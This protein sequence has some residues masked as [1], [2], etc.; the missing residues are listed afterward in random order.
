MIGNNMKWQAFM[1]CAY[2]CS[3]PFIP[4][5]TTLRLPLFCLLLAFVTETNVLGQ[6]APPA[7]NAALTV[8]QTDVALL[9]RIRGLA[10]ETLNHLRD[11]DLPQAMKTLGQA[12][13][14]AV[15]L[16][17]TQVDIGLAPAAAGLHRQ[18]VQLDAQ[19]RFDLLYEWS[20]PVEARPTIRVLTSL[21][22]HDAPPKAF[23]RAIA[24]RPRDNS[25]SVSEVN[26]IDGLFSSAWLLVMSAEET[27][28]LRRLIVELTALTENGLLNAKYVLTLTR[29]VNAKKRD[30]QLEESLREYIDVLQRQR[31][32]TLAGRGPVPHHLMWQ[33]GYTKVNY[34]P[35][36]IDFKPL[37]FWSGSKWQGSA[38]YPDPNLGWVMLEKL[39]GHTGNHL[40][41]V[42]RWIAPADGTLS[43]AGEFKHLYDQG[44][45]IRARII[46]SRFG[47][48]GEWKSLNESVSTTVESFEVQAWDTIDFVADRIDNN[49]FDHFQWPVQLTLMK[50][51]GGVL[52]YD[53][54]AVSPEPLIANVLSKV[55]LAT[56][57][58][59]HKWLQSSG[60]SIIEKLL[61]D[62][63]QGASPL[64]RP[65]LQR[66]RTVA[67][68]RR[69]STTDLSQITNSQPRHWLAADG[70][71]STLHAQGSSRPHW[72][73]YDKHILQLCGADNGALFFRYP[74]VGEFEFSCEVQQG[75]T[76]STDGGLVYGGLQ[77]M[78]DSG[79]QELT[80]LD[81]D[82]A[83][84]VNKPCPFL[85][86]AS[87]PVFNR[88]SIR[89]TAKG[90]TFSVNGHP[91]WTDSRLAELSPWLGL[92]AFGDRRPLFRNLKIIGSPVI[93]RE[94]HLVE[95]AAMR[96][97]QAGFFGELQPSFADMAVS[98]ESP[99]A[100]W[101]VKDGVIHSAK[102]NAED[103]VNPQSWLR[104]Q[105]PLFDGESISYEF[106]YEPGEVV[107]HPA[108][109]R[110][111]FLIEPGGVRLHWITDGVNEWTGLLED[112]AIVEPLNRRGPKPLPLRVGEWNRVRVSLVD[113]V[114]TLT[115]N[116]KVIYVRAVEEES[117]R[118][119]GL[120][121]Y[122][123]RSA[124]R[125]RNVVMVGDWPEEVPAEVFANLT[126]A[127][128]PNQQDA[129]QAFLNDVF[130]EKPLATNVLAICDH[131]GSLSEEERLAF[132]SDWVLPIHGR[133][134]YRLAGVFTT[135]NPAPTDATSLADAG[136]QLVSPAYDLVDV[137]ARLNRLD[138]LRDRVNAFETNDESQQRARFA[139][140]FLVEAAREDQSAAAAA[141][142]ELLTLSERHPENHFESLWPETLVAVR[143]NQNPETRAMVTELSAHLF[144][145]LFRGKSSGSNAWDFQ[146]VSL[147]GQSLKKSPVE[148]VGSQFMMA[149]WI[150]ASVETAQTR[151]QGQ[152]P[153]RW[154]R[155]GDHVVK[156]SPHGDDFL[157]Y[158][159]PLT[160]DFD[161]ECNTSQ[162]ATRFAGLMYGGVFQTL[163]N[164]GAF[165]EGTLRS[166]QKVILNPPLAHEGKPARL[167]IRV[168]D[169]TC[170]TFINGRE[171]SS[172]ELPKGYPPWLA[173]YS[174]A[175]HLSGVRDLRITGKPVVPETVE[176]AAD[177]QLLGW[178]PYFGGSVGAANSG[179]PWQHRES[180]TGSGILGMREPSI[181]GS[182]KE[183]LL[184]YHRPI[185]EDGVIEYDFFYV[186][187]QTL[188]H[189]AFDRLAFML[190]P[191]GVKVHWVT[192]GAYAVA[193]IDPTNQAVEP[194]HR[195][196][197]AA[198][199][200]RANDWNGI[201]V[202]L[203]G[204][205]LRLTLNGQ[206][207]Y[208]R[209]LE[210]TNQRT[211]GLFHYADQTEVRVRNV[212]L[213]GDWPKSVPSVAEQE[214]ADDTVW[215]LDQTRAELPVEFSHSFV[216]DGLA[217]KY[218]KSRMSASS[219][220]APRANGLFASV[221]TRGGDASLQIWPRFT[222]HG[223]FDM[224]LGFEQL[225]LSGDKYAALLLY[226]EH[227]GAQRPY[228][229]VMRMLEQ[230]TYERV[231]VQLSVI[232]PNGVRSYESPQYEA[233]ESTSGRFRLARRGDTF[234]FLFAEGD[235]TNFRI[236]GTQKGSVAETV[237]DG[238]HIMPVCNGASQVNVLLKTFSIRAEKM[239]HLPPD[240]RSSAR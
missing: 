232:R 81:A 59:N 192:D 37:P 210:V 169:R 231:K 78:T 218:F 206:L 233:C 208:E 161:V 142:D 52:K 185:S 110:L 170:T 152:P 109:G 108:L 46:S 54:A 77:F 226:T 227:A 120:F 86:H 207:I 4:L 38:D 26:S 114:V 237:S 154:Q 43:V 147:A 148:T 53:S 111:A 127:R 1:N 51:D 128:N 84:S 172:R 27:G 238:I 105:R 183:R 174:D 44:D 72:L 25:F 222:I 202:E 64:I 115:L 177:E 203:R 76:S 156:L 74:L 60:E 184:Q 141:C 97:W 113:E 71:V 36:E 186:P 125:V 63:S 5:S 87:Q 181:A 12:T 42:L 13:D 229:R 199:P 191:A 75:G 176:L 239:M 159:I 214:L 82:M 100:N 195:R 57:C 194:D 149:N 153:V 205:T 182:F 178:L 70:V 21:V 180:P 48:L 187:G 162:S 49:S 135:T 66:A 163:H 23:A 39:G 56:A 118:Q 198:L 31:P 190:D 132:L 91:S 69:H 3:C 94:V 17:T 126:A 213:R 145:P 96:G 15:S 157:Y 122:S 99:P 22:P 136:G 35:K 130:G 175:R 16:S 104:Y 55:V 221:T 50:P 171:I 215:S 123:S 223:D 93:P 32:P 230:K 133:R 30:E 45:G 83:R 166:N 62:A 224:E 144:D 165:H 95:G 211:F 121:R 212:V 92:R 240:D 179:L 189:P 103:R 101:S 146:M 119:F 2:P 201:A 116:D 14:L 19:E 236:I 173:I 219:R 139:L 90:A 234:Y 151:G 134:F 28:R 7:T 167:R 209:P 117:G 129:D 158:R 89:S 9:A 106:H 155:R 34:T 8:E 29:I 102:R 79:R 138:E 164:V 18:L 197:P 235:S 88:L 140:L 61:K 216:D 58:L 131:A 24:E 112:N 137:A 168:R 200:L 124:V 73:A 20:M 188:V 11:D 10:S 220:I 41:P 85:Q 6:D 40:S 67:V 160:G 68:S 143:G 217:S 107:V 47:T 225:E 80:I 150:P 193:G 204:D 33:F 228:Y 196:G 65:L 98:D